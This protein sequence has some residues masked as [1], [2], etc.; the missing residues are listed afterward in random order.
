M[1]TRVFKFLVM[2]RSRI[3][4]VVEAGP[5]RRVSTRLPAPLRLP[6]VLQTPFPHDASSP[7]TPLEC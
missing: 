7:V 2:I 1:G 5:L 3:V 4:A 6:Q